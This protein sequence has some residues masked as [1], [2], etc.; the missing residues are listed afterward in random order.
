MSVWQ[1]IAIILVCCAG[2]AF[3]TGLIVKDITLRKE[4]E[5]REEKE[6]ELKIEEE[7]R[8]NTEKEIAD[9]IA[10]K[11]ATIEYW[12]GQIERYYPWR[13]CPPDVHIR[14]LID[15]EQFCRIV[16]LP[17]WGYFEAGAISHY[18][19]LGNRY[20][21]FI[22]FGST[23]GWTYALTIQKVCHMYI[24][25]IIP[26]G[27]DQTNF[28]MPEKPSWNYPHIAIPD[29]MMD[30]AH[31]H[32]KENFEYF[33]PYGFKIAQKVEEDEESPS[34]SFNDVM[35]K[36]ADGINAFAKTLRGEDADGTE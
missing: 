3:P 22:P 15:A 5:K 12:L 31:W 29:Y 34:L 7:L 17:S 8:A 20:E 27:N 35:T 36:M 4:K 6:R 18:E 10:R 25:D 26:L 16:R 32:I 13:A 24:V 1:W 23:D 30:R 9:D 14:S 21:L 19:Y 11:R 33:E 2:V 28:N